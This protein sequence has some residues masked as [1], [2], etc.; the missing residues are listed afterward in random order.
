MAKIRVGLIRCDLHAMYYAALMARHD[1]IALR[2]DKVSRGHS[3]YYYFYTHYADPT[4]MTVPHVG[5]FQIAKVWDEDPTKAHVMQA[6]WHDR[7]EVCR[8]CEEVSDDVDLVSSSRTATA[9]VPIICSWPLPAYER[10]FPRSSTSPLPMTL[11]T[12]RNW[13][14][15][16]G[17]T[18]PL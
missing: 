12:P 1:P 5:G 10:A 17:S 2:D 6:I 7:P 4:K 11:L 18:T 8:T 9:M 3:A 14:N 15:S 16:P 13:S